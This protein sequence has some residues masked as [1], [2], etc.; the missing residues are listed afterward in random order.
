MNEK[1]KQLALDAGIHFDASKQS[2]IHFVNTETLEKFAISVV[3]D[4]LDAIVATT[5][6]PADNDLLFYQ[7]L[8][9]AI[10]GIKKRFGV[11]E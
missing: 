5:D 7:G 1:I 9:T 3:Q 8:F 11:E 2:R 6:R 10:D 4:C